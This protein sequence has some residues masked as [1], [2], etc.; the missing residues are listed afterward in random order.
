MSEAIIFLAVLL[1]CN[2]ALYIYDSKQAVAMQRRINYFARLLAAAYTELLVNGKETHLA[3][4]I[5]QAI[6][7]EAAR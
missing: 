6:E 7:E 3:T 5:R 2:I 1:A 4:E